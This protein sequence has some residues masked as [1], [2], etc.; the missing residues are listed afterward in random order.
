MLVVT[1]VC[2]TSANHFVWVLLITTKCLH[3]FSDSLFVNHYSLLVY[4]P[5]SFLFF[6]HLFLSPSLLS[7]WINFLDCLEKLPFYCLIKFKSN[8]WYV[9]KGTLVGGV[10][11][12][13]FVGSLY[14]RMYCSH[15]ERAKK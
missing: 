6:S 14:F 12:S 11:P 10:L 7:V 9:V 1:V 4:F 13:L 3:M 2:T 8:C 5:P 15:Q